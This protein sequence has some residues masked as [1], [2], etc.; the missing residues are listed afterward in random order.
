MYA[1]L[2]DFQTFRRPCSHEK[3]PLLSGT[4]TFEPSKPK[5]ITLYVYK[6]NGTERPI[7]H[8]RLKKTNPGLAFKDYKFGL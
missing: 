6:F 2:P 3:L 4:L 7:L 5:L 1:A 8:L